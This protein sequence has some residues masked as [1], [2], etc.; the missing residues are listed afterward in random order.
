MHILIIPSWYKKNVTAIEAPFIEEQARLIQK[1][2]IKT[3]VFHPYFTGGFKH[4]FKPQTTRKER[5]NDKGL[6]TW[7][8]GETSIVPYHRKTIYNHICNRADALFRKYIEYHGKPDILHAH[9]VFMGGVFVNYFCRKYKIPYIITEHASKLITEKDTLKK[10]EVRF[11]QKVLEQAQRVIFV[12][13]FQKNQMNSLYKIN[14][15]HQQIIPNFVHND[16][17]YTPAEKKKEFTA[18]IL[19]GLTENKNHLLIIKAIEE[20]RKSNIKCYLKIIGDGINRKYLE[21]II[22]FY[23]T[24]FIDY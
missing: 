12:S 23:H 6:E 20:L 19:G 5:I 14:E 10:T 7:Y 17:T 3:A 11:L 9:S 21:N 18:S 8:Y 24:P 2:E 22:L 4:K 13:N 1:Q 15:Q 16:Y